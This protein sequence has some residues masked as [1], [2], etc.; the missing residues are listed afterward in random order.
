MNHPFDAD[1]AVEALGEGRFSAALTDRWNAIGARPNGGYLLATCLNALARSMPFP[2]PFA[3]SAFYLRPAAAGPA[4]LT[5]EIARA[6]R[7]VA[8]GEVRLVQA[9]QE[10][11]RAV[12]TFADLG[13]ARGRTLLVGD[14]PPLAPPPDSIDLMSGGSMPGVT[15]ADRF[16]YRMRAM[17]GWA[18]GKPTGTPAIE[19]WLRFREPR[20]PDV[21]TLALMVDSMFPAVME[22]GEPG[23]A[24]LELTVHVRARPAPGWLACRV[25]TRFVIDGYHEEDFEIWDS[26]GRL[27][28]QSRQLAILPGGA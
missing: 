6:G 10:C 25:V 5:T 11:M 2:D 9:D 15:I 16:E 28:A 22:I 27:V 24:T 8:T 26:A 7:R 12:A 20:E 4:T 13:A 23:S 17:P 21:F 3:V 19:F 1:T 18:R 14:P